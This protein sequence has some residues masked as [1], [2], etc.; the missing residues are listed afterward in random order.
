MSIENAITNFAPITLEGMD[1]VKLMNRIDTK[2]VVS[3]EVLAKILDKISGDFFILEMENKRHFP[4]QSLYYDTVDDFMY[5]AHHNGKLNRYKIR[6]RKY[7]TSNDTFLE[8]KRKVK[9]VRTLKNRILVNTIQ[10]SLEETAKE[11][12]EKYT[13]FNSVDLESKI[14]TNFHRITLVSKELTERVTIDTDL[15]FYKQKDENHQLKNCA[16]IELKRDGNSG[17][18]RLTGVLD[19]FGIRPHGMSKYCLGRA[20]T[21]EELK[22]NNFKPKILTLN[23]IENGNFYYRNY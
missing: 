17:I 6:F 2:Y 18:S 4:Y 13:P 21:E 1:K 19:F 7:V 14:Y 10:N 23:K 16:I 8:V 11:F 20:L 3:K 22:K 9:G 5:K 15:L 12:I